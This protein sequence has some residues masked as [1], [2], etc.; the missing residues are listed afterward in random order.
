MHAV[1]QFVGFGLPVII[2]SV[3]VYSY[4]VFNHI[5]G[6][7]MGMGAMSYDCPRTNDFNLEE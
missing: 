7:F 2:L 3:L 1:V 6:C 4:E 5:L